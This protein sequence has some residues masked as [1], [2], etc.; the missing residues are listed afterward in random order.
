MAWITALSLQLVSPFQAEEINSSKQPASPS[1]ST[2][3]GWLS[4]QPGSH[5]DNSC[6]LPCKFQ[7]SFRTRETER[8]MNHKHLAETYRAIL[9]HSPRYSRAWFL[10]P[11]K[12][13]ATPT[14]EHRAGEQCWSVWTKG[15][16][17]AVASDWKGKTQ[18]KPVTMGHLK[19]KLEI[20]LCSPTLHERLTFLSLHLSFVSLRR[21]K[22]RRE[23][24]VC[25]RKEDRV[26]TR[27]L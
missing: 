1:D 6:G 9:F 21:R 26:S 25:W 17:P 18:P 7:S 16:L 20:L 19:N 27:H 24:S 8:R 13:T 2:T 5:V 10:P 4:H 11:G 15:H 3:A 14:N 22:G 23:R 12:A